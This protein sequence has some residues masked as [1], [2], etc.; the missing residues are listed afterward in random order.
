[1]YSML[2]V[3]DYAMYGISNSTGWELF[4]G[5]A[6]V[7]FQP[8]GDYIDTGNAGNAYV[9]VRLN[10]TQ[11]LAV[12]GVNFEAAFCVV[13]TYAVKGEPPTFGTPVSLNVGLDEAIIFDAVFMSTGKV[14]IDISASEGSIRYGV[15]ATIVGNVITLGTKT[16]LESGVVGLYPPN[17]LARYDNTHVISAWKNEAGQYFIGSITLNVDNTPTLNTPLSL[18][19][20]YNQGGFFIPVGKVGITCSPDDFV[21]VVLKDTIAMRWNAISLPITNA[22]ETIGSIHATLVL[23]SQVPVNCIAL[24]RTH[25]FQFFA[26]YS[27]IDDGYV[28]SAFLCEGGNF[29]LGTTKVVFVPFAGG[30]TAI[31][32][33][34]FINTNNAFFQS[35]FTFKID[36]SNVFTIA[37]A[38]ITPLDN[39]F[40]LT[41]TYTPVNSNNGDSLGEG[42]GCALTSRSII[43]PGYPYNSDNYGV[44]VLMLPNSLQLPYQFFKFEVGTSLIESSA[45]GNLGSTSG[46]IGTN[47][48]IIVSANDYSSYLIPGVILTINDL[49]AYIVGSALFTLTQTTVTITSLLSSTYVAATSKV[50]LV[51]SITS[52]VGGHE[53][54]QS[55]GTLKPILGN[56][57]GFP[58]LCFYGNYNSGT[59]SNLRGESLPFT[60]AFG[61][62]RFLVAKSTNNVTYLI[63]GIDTENVRYIFDIQSQGVQIQQSV[64]LGAYTLNSDLTLITCARSPLGLNRVWV[65]GVLNDNLDF[66]GSAIGNDLNYMWGT[67]IDLAVPF[68]GVSPYSEMWCGVL[69]DE[70]IDAK[71]AE[72]MAIYGI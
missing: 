8:L 68:S 72:I 30:D 3:V 49:D 24:T 32:M 17:G 64:G 48:L 43:F 59:A 41:E 56:F 18:P 69:D 46:T 31:Q 38:C 71:N 7:P 53:L 54:V 40:I 11:F 27:I 67:R 15:V 44:S 60:M 9:T 58:T 47:Q 22:G 63:D 61:S 45:S 42:I 13:G 12:Y 14:Y 70:E 50:E 37:I 4:N 62:T 55:N 1:M 26:G 39:N 10:N 57:N 52:T 36:S 19:A 5:T 6:T 51:S 65:N 29:T 28:I 16:L 35:L 33:V 2:P 34:S 66:V 20:K 25:G 21:V 23:S